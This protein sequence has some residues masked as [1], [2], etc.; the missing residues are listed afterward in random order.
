MDLAFHHP[1]GPNLITDCR[2]PTQQSSLVGRNQATTSR[3]QHL[4]TE[5]QTGLRKLKM[6]PTTVALIDVHRLKIPRAKPIRNNHQ[7][8]VSYSF[9]QKLKPKSTYVQICPKM[10]QISQQLALF[11]GAGFWLHILSNNM[12]IRTQPASGPSCTS[13]LVA[14]P[15]MGS[16][17][18]LGPRPSLALSG[19]D[20]SR[21]FQ[22]SSKLGHCQETLFQILKKAL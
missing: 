2:K 17:C 4:I 6:A 7:G 13:C 14:S 12:G 19:Y 3:F 20:I 15:F 21:G 10:S 1:W 11:W 22:G 16:L 5:S 9:Q 18:V 8:K